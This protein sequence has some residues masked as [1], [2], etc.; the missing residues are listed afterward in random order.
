VAFSLL[1]LLGYIT[2][3]MLNELCLTGKVTLSYITG[4][5]NPPAVPLGRAGRIN[6]D[7]TLGYIIF[8][9]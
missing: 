5:L 4:G 7:E 3:V 9:M 1:L 2:F 6:L 8:I